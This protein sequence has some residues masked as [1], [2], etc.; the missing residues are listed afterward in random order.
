MAQIPFFKMVASGN[1]FIVIDNRTGLVKDPIRFAREACAAHTGVGADGVLLLEASKKAVFK[2]R[3]LNSDGSEAEACG[4]GYRCIA[5]YAK[6]VLK[7]P[8]RFQFE[9]TASLIQAEVLSHGVRVQLAPPSELHLDQELEVNGRRLHYAFINT[10]VPHVVIFVE[11]LSKIDVAGLGRAIREHRDFKPR[12][13]NVNF[14]E[15]KSKQ[16]I[17]VRTY[18]R[19]VENETL[20]CGTGSSGSAIVSA[21]KGYAQA[22]VRVKT[23]GGEILSIGFTLK[24]RTV[25]GVT[26]EGPAQF[27]YE[28][29]LLNGKG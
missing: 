26:L 12:G 2:M 22:P 27:V 4:N 20:A 28:G 7:L 16:E 15:V 1:D 6:K 19:G 24:G 23:S 10:G 5:L 13:T 25:S 14:V 9:A 18:E 3:I 21:L 11:G 8:P 17:H 29:K